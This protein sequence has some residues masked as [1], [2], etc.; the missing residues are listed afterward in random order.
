MI[1]QIARHS[2]TTGIALTAMLGVFNNSSAL[3]QT[4]ANTA[5]VATLPTND[6]SFWPT[7]DDRAP[8]HTV[9]GASRDGCSG[10]QFT[11]LLPSSRYGL[12]RQSHPEL[13]IATSDSTARQALFSVHSD[14]YYYETYIELPATPGIV[15]IALPSNA[16]ALASNKLYQWSLMLVCNHRIGPDSPT[17][18]GWIQTQPDIESTNADISLQQATEYRDAHLWY[19]MISL[20]ADLRLQEPNNKVVHQAWQSMLQGNDLVTV[21]NIPILGE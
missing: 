2:I 13:L 16:P 15:S 10:E 12:T 1:K 3:A 4:T 18:I 19:D 11:A 8:D 14:D 7:D 17:L 6:W 20:L 5:E 9:S 21:A